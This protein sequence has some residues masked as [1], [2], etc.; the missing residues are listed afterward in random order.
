[1]KALRHPRQ[2]LSAALL[3]GLLVMV[4]AGGLFVYLADEVGEQAWLA[5][6]DLAAAQFFNRHSVWWLARVFEAVTFFGDP[7]TITVIGLAVALGLATSRRWS[8]LAGWT[9]AL[10]GTALLNTT[11][12]GVFQR[13]RPQLPEPWITETGWS[14]PSGHAMG[15]LV[16]YGFLAYLVSRMSPAG[17][18]R[19]TA[20]T[21][22]AS[23]VLLIGFS[24]IY[25][26]V[27]YLS[28]VIGGYAAA[29]VWLAFCILITRSFGG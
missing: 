12:K 2:W 26:G 14:F 19:R 13:L 1:M 5:S 7:G 21:V 20:V 24:R 22:L 16:A 10:I 11:L 17:F 9:A 6:F 25:L 29:T 27:H 18:P 15:S 8:L 28:D 23:L 3:A 4:A